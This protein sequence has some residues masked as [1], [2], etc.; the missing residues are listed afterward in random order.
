M[1]RSLGIHA[2][3]SYGKKH[4]VTPDRTFK[5]RMRKWEHYSEDIN[6]LQLWQ[7]ARNHT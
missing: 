1:A 5:P 4:A 6:A 2:Q 7:M 3:R